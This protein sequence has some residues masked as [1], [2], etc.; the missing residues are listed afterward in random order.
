MTVDVTSLV[1]L[2]KSMWYPLF[3][4]RGVTDVTVEL[5]TPHRTKIYWG[6]SGRTN[7]EYSLSFP[8]PMSLYKKP[9]TPKD[10]D[11]S[12]DEESERRYLIK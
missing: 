11:V 4:Y 8:L 12:I 3:E 5:T 6:A 2:I 9:P 10:A 1:L 7:A